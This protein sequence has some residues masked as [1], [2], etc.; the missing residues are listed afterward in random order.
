MQQGNAGAAIAVSLDERRGGAFVAGGV[1]DRLGR[2]SEVDGGG[3]GPGLGSDLVAHVGA[4]IRSG[5]G[6]L[7][8]QHR[9]KMA[10]FVEE[11]PG[12]EQAIGVDDEAA[13]R[14]RDARQ[15]GI[16]AEGSEVNGQADLCRSQSRTR[17]AA[18]SSIGMS[19]APMRAAVHSGS[20]SLEDRSFE[21]PSF[22]DRCQPCEHLFQDR[23]RDVL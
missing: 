10:S 23:V 22:E 4:G 5:G 17:V 1:K 16:S 11:I 15:E 20:R 9:G 18:G 2:E 8:G 3:I 6:A 19:L 21:C 7:L 13:R 14:E 12:V